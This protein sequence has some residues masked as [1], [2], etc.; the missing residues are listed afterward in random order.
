MR[1]MLI[2][3]FRSNYNPI[4]PEPVIIIINR[5]IEGREGEEEMISSSELNSLKEGTST[6]TGTGT[7]TTIIGED[8]TSS[9]PLIISRDKVENNNNNNELPLSK[10]KHV[11][12]RNEII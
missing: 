9:N 3:L 10:E 7:G 8:N 5:L 12:I 1:E 4:Y 11:L 6:G 2:N